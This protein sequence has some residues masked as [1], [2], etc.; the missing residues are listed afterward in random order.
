MSSRDT[1][2]DYLQKVGKGSWTYNQSEITYN[3]L[4]DPINSLS[5][6]YNGLGE[7]TEWTN[8]DLL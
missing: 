2:W 8:I 3:Q 4:L 5:V 1:Q 6:V 7:V